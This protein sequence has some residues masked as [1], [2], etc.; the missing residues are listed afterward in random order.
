[1]V[2]HGL[3]LQIPMDNPYCSCK[4]SI[5]RPG[6]A[7][8]GGRV[9]QGDGAVHHGQ[10]ACD[11]GGK[12]PVAKR[13][14]VSLTLR[15]MCGYF[16]RS[17]L[18]FLTFILWNINGRLNV[19]LAAPCGR[20]SGSCWCGAGKEGANA[21]TVAL[22]RPSPT[23]VGEGASFLGEQCRLWVGTGASGWKAGRRRRRR[24]GHMMRLVA[25]RHLG[26]GKPSNGRGTRISV[27]GG[28][29]RHRGL[30]GGPRAALVTAAAAAAA[31]AAAVRGDGNDEVVVTRYV[32]TSLISQWHRDAICTA[33]RLSDPGG[34]GPATSG[35]P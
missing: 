6:A 24:R 23:S 18:P 1:M 30:R 2:S 25:R 21:D 28:G 32:Q 17:L 4:L 7:I 20:R 16:L 22:L 12:G 35:R 3:Q 15:L 9:A 31:A 5:L 27:S 11:A 34:G 8:R 33:L 26:W 13:A 14:R 29:A 19:C 10:A